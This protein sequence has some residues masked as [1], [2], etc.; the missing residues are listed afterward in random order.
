LAY[1]IDP[2]PIALIAAAVLPGAPVSIERH[3]H[4]PPAQADRLCVH[5]TDPRRTARIDRW[6]PG[7]ARET[8]RRSSEARAPVELD[9]E[10]E[11]RL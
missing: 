1:M 8:W 5:A 11:L 6:K 3:S 9:F 2:L 7:R 10:D 4:R